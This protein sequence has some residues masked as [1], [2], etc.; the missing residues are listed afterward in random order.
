MNARERMNIVIVGHV[1]HG[2]STVIGRLLADT[3]SLPD[4]KL[5]QVKEMCRRSSKPFE[6]AFLL[7]ALK[8][9]RSQGITIDTARSFF[10]TKKRDY[11]IID[12]PGHIE[13]LKNMITGA[14]RAE[15]ALLVIDAHEGIQE[16]SKRHGHMVSMLGVKQVSVLV[17]KM[18]MMGYDENVFDEIKKTYTGFLKQIGVEPVSFIPISAR[19]G[20]NIVGISTRMPWHCGPTVLAQLDLFE[21]PKDITRKPFRFPVQEIYKFTRNNDDRRIVAGTV[22]SGSAKVGDEVIFLPSQKKSF[23]KS[24]EAFNSPPKTAAR[25]GDATG[26]TFMTQI[27]IRPGDIMAKTSEPLPHVG[28]RFKANIFWVGRAPMIKG[29][30][31][32]LKLAAARANARLVEIKQ[33]IDASDLSTIAGKQQLDRHD[34]A[35]CVFETSKPLAFDIAA[36]NEGTGRF[37]IVDNY[38]IAGG[39]VILENYS[40]EDSI[41]KQ[42][43]R[44]RESIWE[45]GLIAP[46]RRA[47]RQKHKSKFIAFTGPGGVGKR[48]IA[49]ALEKELFV[50]EYNTYYLGMTNIEHGLDA[51]ISGDSDERIRRLGELARI[52]TDAG[53]IFITTIDDADDYDIETLK[54]LNEPNEIL[55]V[56][57]GENNFSR[58]SADLEIPTRK[59]PEA[60]VAGVLKLLKAKDVILEYY[61]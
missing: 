4:G 51:D 1:D 33:A 25:A 60:A 13:F 59:N 53:M 19:E 42:H 50:R 28:G 34:V 35:E 46:E 24:I 37:V 56:T 17:N 57:V 2:K 47:Q 20:E 16:N 54:F 11:I 29:K 38:E 22:D 8:D 40:S 43:V 31:Y 30:T 12:A 5:E 10:K 6:Y 58:Y 45:K 14:A 48:D 44:A 7:D 61:L 27:Y 36:D 18:D 49:K 52:M 15:A 39:G 32:K 3:G 21:C 23:I 26:F 9:E 55:V 41:L